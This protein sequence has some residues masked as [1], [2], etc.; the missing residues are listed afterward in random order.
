MSVH[1]SYYHLLI[2]LIISNKAY[3][4]IMFIISLI[5]KYIKFLDKI[6]KTIFTL[7]E[8]MTLVNIYYVFYLNF[9]FLYIV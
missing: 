6:N 7:I 5:K 8:L 9:R 1:N 3:F 4:T 2:K